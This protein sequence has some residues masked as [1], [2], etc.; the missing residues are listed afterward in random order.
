MSDHSGKDGWGMTLPCEVGL[1]CPF[2]HSD[3]DGMGFCSFPDA[4]PKRGVEYALICNMKTIDCEMVGS[5]E[6]P[7]GQLLD[8]YDAVKDKPRAYHRTKVTVELR[9]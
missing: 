3:A 5:P 7:L 8:G 2:W 6:T 4:E 9:E 1:V